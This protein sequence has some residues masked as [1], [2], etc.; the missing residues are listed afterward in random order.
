MVGMAAF[1]A[2]STHAPLTAILLLFEMTN[3]YSIILPLMV[4]VVTAVLTARTVE[5]ESI[6][7]MKL[8]RRGISLKQAPDASL[9][10]ITPVSEIMSKKVA[11]IDRDFPIGKLGRQFNKTKRT[12]FPVVDSDGK[13][14]GIVTYAEA[15]AAYNHEPPPSAD[16]PIGNIMRNPGKP[17]Y[18]EDTAG[19]VIRRMSHDHLDRLPV[20]DPKDP[21]KILGIVSRTDLLK[22][23]S[24][25][26]T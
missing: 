8:A 6:Y 13:L 3:D 20:V 17:L 15:Q 26:I 9:L 24:K 4:A 5:P 11:T 19:E 12:G 1:V 7:T 14:V 25:K 2:G 21:K 10:N 16:M 18:P 23:Y 22:L